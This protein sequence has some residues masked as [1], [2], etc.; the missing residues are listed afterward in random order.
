MR[1]KAAMLLAACMMAG[2]LAGCGGKEETKNQGDQT[3]TQQPLAFSLS[4]PV[5]TNS[6]YQAKVTNWDND[7]LVQHLE[8]LTNTDISLQILEV[9]KMSVM[10]AS[11]DIPDV[12]GSYDTPTG[13][14]M[15][16]SVEAGM[17]LPLDDLL[18]EYA[19]NLLSKVPQAAWDMVSYEGKIYGIPDYL[20]NPSRRGT[21]IRTDL[22]EQTGLETPTTVDEYLDVL[23][24][25]K[26]LG[27]ENPYQMRENFKYADVILG[28]FDVL[29]YKD[30]FEVVDGQVQPK[31]FDVENMQK[32]LETYKTMYDEGLIPKDFATISSSDYSKNINSGK[33]GSWSA[34]AASL[35]STRTGLTQAVPT[36][37]I[38][39]IP[40]P[41]GPE[42]KGGYFLYTPVN[43]V[44]YISKNV[45]QEKAVGIV[46]FYEWMTTE[47]AETFFTFGIE[48]DNYTLENGQINYK[49]PATAEEQEEE[50]FRTG[51]LWMGQD[52]T[53]LPARKRLELNDDGQSLLDAFDNVLNKEGLGGIGFYPDLTT[54]SQYPDL[55]ATGDTGPKLI[56][57]HMIKMIYGREPIS[58]WPKVIEEYLAKGGSEI[59]KE[60]NE[61]YAANDGIVNTARQ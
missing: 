46:K 12:V 21:Y 57:D 35:I 24:A 54:Y 48:G 33:S 2:A 37:A 59:L 11:N 36:A 49:I 6:G 5:T 17:F 23:R 8:K 3:E 51:M 43:R 28:A 44:F 55:S 52:S 15:S 47:E 40:A 39:I 22:L 32:A 13:K 14:N 31:F 34:N 50:S 61:R 20:S 26:Q 19:P 60:A 10:F 18:K 4:I 53:L 27:V 30:Q 7:K 9:S 16:G 42:G 38:D 25:F 45:S 58:D 29:P 1:K 56:I 41:T